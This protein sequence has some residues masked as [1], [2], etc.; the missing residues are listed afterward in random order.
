MFYILLYISK[1]FTVDIDDFTAFVFN[2]PISF[3][4]GWFI[5]FS[6]Y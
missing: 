1:L 3:I 2:L 5:N 4:C 6:I